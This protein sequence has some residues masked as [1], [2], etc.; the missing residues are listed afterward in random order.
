MKNISDDSESQAFSSTI[1]VIRGRMFRKNAF[2]IIDPSGKII[3]LAKPPAFISSGIS[4]Y[5]TEGEEL[6]ACQNKSSLK[7]AYISGAF[8]HEVKDCVTMS[9]MGDLMGLKNNNSPEGVE[10]QIRDPQKT[11]VG[12]I[13]QE[14][15][16]P[17]VRYGGKP[18]YDIMTGWIGDEKVFVFKVDINSFRFNMSADFSMDNCGLTDRRL[19]LALAVLFSCI[20][21]TQS[22]AT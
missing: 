15:T 17:E 10:W 2:D 5:T 21:R 13:T 9:I 12:R 11:P 6:I 22:S 18:M 20:K 3:L 8:I 7:D 14:A 19:G 4:I 1:Y 16:A